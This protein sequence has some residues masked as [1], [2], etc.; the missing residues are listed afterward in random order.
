MS[1]V[2]SHLGTIPTVKTAELKCLSIIPYVLQ[3]LQAFCYKTFPLS[4]FVKK[5]E[6]YSGRG[7]EKYNSSP[8]TG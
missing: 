6:K 1:Q 7:E 8:V 3:L 2:K 4:N 5:E